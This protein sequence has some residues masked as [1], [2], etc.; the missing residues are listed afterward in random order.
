MDQAIIDILKAVW[1]PN[2]APSR[3]KKKIN[4]WNNT[5]YSELPQL[6]TLST[7]RAWLPMPAAPTG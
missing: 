2:D 4:A 3:P 1:E 5:K 7:A 6:V